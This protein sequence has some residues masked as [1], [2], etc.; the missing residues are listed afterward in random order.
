MPQSTLLVCCGD[1]E[2]LKCYLS[3][4]KKLFEFSLKY[5]KLPAVSESA[6][7]EELQ[8]K[9]FNVFSPFFFQALLVLAKPW[10]LI[11]LERIAEKNCLLF[12]SN[13]CKDEV[14]ILMNRNEDIR[15]V[16]DGFYE[17]NVGST[18]MLL[19]DVLANLMTCCMPMKTAL[20]ASSFSR[21]LC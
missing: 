10:I 19:E 6:F 16:F 4:H 11:H 20:V 12:H 3:F 7:I 2:N 18:A 1:C 13:Q 17:K 5:F 21:R 14:K 9:T 8:K 15:P